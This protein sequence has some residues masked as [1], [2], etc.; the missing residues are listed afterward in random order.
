MNDVQRILE[1]GMTVADLIEE[2]KTFEPDARV[3]FTCDYGDMCHTQQALP[4]ESINR[5]KEYQRIEESAYSKSGIALQDFN[6]DHC[7]EEEWEDTMEQNGSVVVL[8]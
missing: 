5:V 6:E 4:V 8:S 1:R 3:V 2:L 7:D